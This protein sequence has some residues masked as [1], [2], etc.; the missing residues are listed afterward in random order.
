M[1]GVGDVSSWGDRTCV[2]APSFLFPPSSFQAT[3]L[4]L[5]SQPL[6]RDPVA[7]GFLKTAGAADLHPL[8]SLAEPVSRPWCRSPGPLG[9]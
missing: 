4:S 3:A 8:P 6:G 2:S 7:T 5:Q 1:M 9:C